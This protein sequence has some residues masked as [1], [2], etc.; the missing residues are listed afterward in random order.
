MP[1]FRIFT[2]SKA[3]IKFLK[4]YIEEVFDVSLHEEDFDT[5]G[6]WSGYKSDESIKASIKQNSIDDEKTSILIL[7]ADKDFTQRQQEVLNDFKRFNINLFLFPNNRDAGSLENMLCEIAIEKQIIKCFEDYES[8]IKGHETPVIKSK[9]FAYLDA[10]LPSVNKK[11]DK[12][13]LIQDKNRDYRNAA[14]WNL[15]HK[16]LNP[17]KEFLTPF[18][19]KNLPC[20]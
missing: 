1:N 15:H 20:V 11:N 18:F 3:D 13:D 7:D 2:E 6:S 8:C 19:T 5:L 4:D 9:V 14:H 12:K 17:L 10:L 16:F